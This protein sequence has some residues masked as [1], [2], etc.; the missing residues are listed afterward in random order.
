MC[1]QNRIH[2]EVRHVEGNLFVLVVIRCS[3]Q[4]LV[5]DDCFVDWLWEL[6]Q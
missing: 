4:L 2:R 5:C 6:G 1:P 3:A